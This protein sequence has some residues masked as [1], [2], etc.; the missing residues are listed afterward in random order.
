MRPEDLIIRSEPPPNLWDQW[1]IREV[2]SESVRP[3]LEVLPLHRT[4]RMGLLKEPRGRY[5]PDPPPGVALAT[6]V[7]EV[8]PFRVRQLDHVEEV[9]SPLVGIHHPK[10]PLA[11]RAFELD[12]A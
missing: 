8:F 12:Q 11:Q 5:L 7:A 10:A 9:F 2:F 6:S 4:Q 3:I 1:V